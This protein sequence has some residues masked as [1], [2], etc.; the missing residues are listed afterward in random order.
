LELSDQIGLKIIWE[1]ER[2]KNEYGLEVFPRFQEGNFR[3]FL[4][5]ENK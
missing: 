1:G 3:D 4:H 5:E 2:G